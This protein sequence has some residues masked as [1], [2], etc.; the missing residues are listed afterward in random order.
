[1]FH[2]LRTL[3]QPLGSAIGRQYSQLKKQQQK[4]T[5]Q[6]A[7]TTEQLKSAKLQGELEQLA[8]QRL[9]LESAHNSYH[10]SLHAIT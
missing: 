10:Q 5:E 6:L 8:V 7:K 1:L 4:L 9:D 3:S 2:G